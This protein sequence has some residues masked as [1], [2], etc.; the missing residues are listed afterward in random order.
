MRGR[1]DKASRQHNAKRSQHQ[2]W[3]GGCPVAAQFGLETAVEQDDRQRQGAD[4]I[5]RQVIVETDAEQAV[6][7]SQEPDAKEE[8]E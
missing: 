6:L 7:A 1:A 8:Q 4:E 2:R 3:R 5:G